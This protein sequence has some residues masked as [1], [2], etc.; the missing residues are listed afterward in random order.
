ML[1]SCSWLCS[2]LPC[3]ALGCLDDHV[4]SRNIV[5]IA[6]SPQPHVSR[7]DAGFPRACLAMVSI[8]LV[9]LMLVSLMLRSLVLVSI[10]LVSRVLRSLVL[11]SRTLE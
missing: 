10:M 2:P 11:V 1:E 9:S 5:E 3:L 7:H 8:M 4:L 6:C